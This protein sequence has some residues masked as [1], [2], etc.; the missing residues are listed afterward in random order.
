MALFEDYRCGSCGNRWSIAEDPDVECGGDHQLT[1]LHC[2]ECGIDA[3]LRT[4]GVGFECII[5][6]VA[7][8]SRE[9]S[10]FDTDQPR[11]T[12]S[13]GM[14]DWS[15]ISSRYRGSG[16]GIE[17]WSRISPKFDEGLPSENPDPDEDSWSL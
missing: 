11:I 9:K 13:I 6:V 2:F 5:C 10:F 16:L 12:G 1:V 15:R 8:V 14:E 7:H 4:Y 3:D 17:D